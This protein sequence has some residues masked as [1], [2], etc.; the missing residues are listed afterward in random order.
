MTVN[1]S[2]SVMAHSFREYR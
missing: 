2:L 1:I